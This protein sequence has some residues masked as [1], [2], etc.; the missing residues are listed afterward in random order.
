MGF[1]LDIENGLPCGILADPGEG[2]AAAGRV[3]GASDCQ[4][5]LQSVKSCF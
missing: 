4:V 1:L 5:F 2:R 3:K